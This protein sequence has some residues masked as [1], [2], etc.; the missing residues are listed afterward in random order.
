MPF[1]NWFDDYYESIYVPAI[2][3]SDLNPRRADDLYRPSAIVHD[4]WAMTQE[5]KVILADLSNK[6]P[7]V[8]YELG[9]AH[10]IAKPVILVTASM[11]DVP[12]DLRSL[13]V[14]LYDKNDPDWGDVL[15]HKITR[16][17]RE[18]LATPMEAVLPAFLKVK[19][20]ADKK[21]ISKEGKELISLR[22]ELDIMKLQ[23]QNGPRSRIR[24]RKLL[25]NAVDAENFAER[26]LKKYPSTS[27]EELIE[28]LLE[29]GVPEEKYAIEVLRDVRRKIK[30]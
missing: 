22:Q 6:N 4:I 25:D 10:A 20:S 28:I 18:I 5:A 11:E 3:S 15:K 13:R 2:K 12:F 17:I 9:L 1:G 27:D 26:Y 8:F 21:S 19:K 7:N 30:S 29:E 24:P 16:A 23:M 14:L